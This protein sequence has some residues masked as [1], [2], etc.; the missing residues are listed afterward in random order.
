MEDLD[1]NDGAAY[2]SDI[3]TAGILLAQQGI[4]TPFIKLIKCL[5]TLYLGLSCLPINHS[6]TII[7]DDH[8]FI[9]VIIVFIDRNT[10]FHSFPPLIV[11][12]QRINNLLKNS[13]HTCPMLLT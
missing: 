11:N 10:C 12:W 1:N 2:I 4:R 6:I 7:G 13:M 5:P 3:Q 9:M 8:D